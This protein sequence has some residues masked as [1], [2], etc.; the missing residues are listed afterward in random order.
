MNKHIK[1]TDNDM[2]YFNNIFRLNYSSF[3]QICNN[4]DYINDRKIADIYGE[5][6]D[7]FEDNM[8]NIISI[9]GASGGEL[10]E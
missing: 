9:I 5:A 10:L 7:L 2:N 6:G 1:I 4:I 3:K 8:D